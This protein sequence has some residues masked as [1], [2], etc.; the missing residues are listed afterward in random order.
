MTDTLLR[1]QSLSAR[2]SEDGRSADLA[3]T[4]LLA[5]SAQEVAGQLGDGLLAEADRGRARAGQLRQGRAEIVAEE[6]SIGVIP[7]SPF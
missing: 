1:A 5:E 4:G 3:V 7:T 6:E 2:K